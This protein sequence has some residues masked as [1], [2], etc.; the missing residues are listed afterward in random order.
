MVG[1]VRIFTTKLTAPWVMPSP[2]MP[3]VDTAVVF[4]ATVFFEGTKV[5]EGRGTTRPFEIVGA[6]YINGREYA[7]ALRI[8]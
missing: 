8:T 1:R 2:N 4:P 3:T 7:D 5:S 6:P